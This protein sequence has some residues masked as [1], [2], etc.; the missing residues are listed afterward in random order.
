[1]TTDI[2]ERDREMLAILQDGLPLTSRP[3]AVIADLLDWSEEE[4]LERLDRLVTSGHVRKVGAVINS[5]RIGAVSTL[6]AVDVPE[7]RID[8]AASIINA[9]P[10]VTHNYL[11][12]GHPNMWFTLT[13]RGPELLEAN[14]AR[15]ETDIGADIIRMPA[16]RM[17]K[18]GVKYDL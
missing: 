8:E 6:A 2:D 7:D 18:I 15:I 10:G 9:Y 12:E 17:F 5:K 13:E 1:M 11:R 3:F 16:T 4:V 14:L